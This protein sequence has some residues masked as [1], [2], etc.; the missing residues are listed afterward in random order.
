MILLELTEKEA[1]LI[2]ELASSKKG[3][4]ANTNGSGF[5]ERERSINVCQSILNKIETAFQ[6]KKEVLITYK[7]L[8]NLIDL[9]KREYGHIP[10]DLHISNQR[11]E[12]NYFKYI[13]LANA[14]IMWLNGRGLLKRLARFDYI[15]KSCE[16][17]ENE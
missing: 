16:Y 1:Q 3:E 14:L 6:P 15:D 11:V 10:S 5:V 7:D 13:S 17:E 2:G 8:Y 4:L 12:E 9:S